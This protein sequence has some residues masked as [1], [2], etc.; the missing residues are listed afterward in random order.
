MHDIGKCANLTTFTGSGAILTYNI[1]KDLGMP[2]DDRTEIMIAIG[3][4][5][6]KNYIANDISAALI[7]ADV[8]DVHNN[9]FAEINKAVI[10]SNLII[11]EKNRS[12]K[13]DLTI[14]TKVCSILEYFEIFMDKTLICKN[15]A[16]YLNSSFKLVIND[17][18]LV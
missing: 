5:E 15:A 3:T 10:E 18:Q 17:T 12:I 13:L 11:E 8:S 16:K 9:F 14:D 6:E 7:L 1:L 2:R 4:H